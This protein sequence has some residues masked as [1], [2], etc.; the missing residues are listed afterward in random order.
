MNKIILLI[1][2]YITGERANELGL[3]VL[4]IRQPADI[5]AIH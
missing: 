1:K 4:I 5:F 2:N 3:P